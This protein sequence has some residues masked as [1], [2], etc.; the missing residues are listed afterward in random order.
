M[1]GCSRQEAVSQNASMRGRLCGQSCRRSN[2]MGASC[3]NVIINV[4]VLDD[5]VLL[6]VRAGGRVGGGMIAASKPSRS[7][8][9]CGVWLVGWFVVFVVDSRLVWF[10]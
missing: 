7:G 6:I 1:V 8:V 3:G 10:V 9:W 2:R 5:D 4:C